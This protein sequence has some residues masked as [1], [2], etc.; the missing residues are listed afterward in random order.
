V[1]ESLR[2]DYFFSCLIL[3]QNFWK[4]VKEVWSMRNF[5]FFFDEKSWEEEE[6][7]RSFKFQHRCEEFV[8]PPSQSLFPLSIYRYTLDL[9][10]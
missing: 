8:P 4:K 7:V 10:N 1:Q 5:F 9:Q 3:S 6:G 2:Y